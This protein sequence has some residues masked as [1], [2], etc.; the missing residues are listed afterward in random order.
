MWLEEKVFTGNNTVHFNSI[1]FGRYKKLEELLIGSQMD[2]NQ[3]I[4][5]TADDI[6]NLIIDSEYLLIETPDG[7]KREVKLPFVQ[8]T[9]QN[10]IFFESFD[11]YQ[12]AYYG[13]DFDVDLPDK[14]FSSFINLKPKYFRAASNNFEALTL[15]GA[16]ELSEIF[17]IG[18]IYLNGIVTLAEKTPFSFKVLN[19]EREPTKRALGANAF[20]PGVIARE[21]AKREAEARIQEGIIGI[22]GCGTLEKLPIYLGKVGY[23]EKGIDKRKKER[24]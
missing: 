12:D 11:H 4:S 6:L 5:Q 18:F 13:A 22:I 9:Y 2:L 7:E 10:P 1:E 8:R 14:A 15:R 24:H 21:E 17:E 23:E 16:D 3:T 20:L 19:K